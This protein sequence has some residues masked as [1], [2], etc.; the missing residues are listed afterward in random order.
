M[1][2]FEFVT[3]MISMILALTLGQ[4]LSGTSFLLKTTREVRWHWPHTLWMATLGIDLVNHWWAL[5]D[6]HEL[7]WNY[8]SFLYILIAPILLALA[9]GLIVPDRTA[10]STLDMTRH[11]GRVRRPFAAL[12]LLYVLAMWF[13]GPILAGQNPLGAVGA[14]HVPILIGTLLALTSANY[15]ANVVAP[16][17]ISASLVMVMIVR[18]MTIG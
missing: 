16:L 11:F 9:V 5:W 3:V 4:L 15:R 17:L 7:A 2:L 1:S 10:T 6:F 13:D 18:F 8:A 14:L 12:F